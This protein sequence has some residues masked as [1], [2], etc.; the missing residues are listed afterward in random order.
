[1]CDKDTAF[2]EMKEIAPTLGLPGYPLLLTLLPLHDPPIPS[3]VSLYLISLLPPIPTNGK[4]EKK[5]ERKKFLRNCSQK[6]F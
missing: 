3:K 4:K 2:W 5:K 6:I 1:M